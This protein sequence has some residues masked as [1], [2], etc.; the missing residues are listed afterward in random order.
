M[1]EN[2]VNSN[3]TLSLIFFAVGLILTL[4]RKKII[5][6]I[7]PSKKGDYPVNVRENILLIVGIV[8]TIGGM[9]LFLKYY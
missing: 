4:F 8:F 9:L 2:F 7:E 6:V 5:R 1:R 3:A